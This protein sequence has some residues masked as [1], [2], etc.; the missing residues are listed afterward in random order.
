[1][2][3]VVRKI[4]IQGTAN[5]RRFLLC[6]LLVL[7]PLL[8][9]LFVRWLLDLHPFEIA[10]P[11]WVRVGGL[12]V[13]GLLWWW[14]LPAIRPFRPSTPQ[15]YSERL[16]TWAQ[17]GAMVLLGLLGYGIWVNYWPGS[18]LHA[19]PI[20]GEWT[21]AAFVA[22]GLAMIPTANPQRLPAIMVTV[23]VLAPPAYVLLRLVPWQVDVPQ[24]PLLP[25]TVGSWGLAWVIYEIYMVD[26]QRKNSGP[27]RPYGSSDAGYPLKGGRVIGIFA[28][29]L[30]LAG[31]IYVWYI[32]LHFFLVEETEFEVPLLVLILTATSTLLYLPLLPYRMFL[33]YGALEETSNLGDVKH[34]RRARDRWLFEEFKRFPIVPS[35][36]FE[37]SREIGWDKGQGDDGS[38]W[39]HYLVMIALYN[40]AAVA[41][42]LVRNLARLSYPDDRIHILLLTEKKER[43]EVDG[44]GT[45]ARSAPGASAPLTYRAARFFGKIRKDLLKYARDLVAGLLGIIVYP[46]IPR[47]FARWQSRLAREYT[48]GDPFRRNNNPSGPDQFTGDALVHGIGMLPEN[49]RQRF[50]V[51]VVPVAEGTEPQTKPRAL[52]Y[53]LYGHRDL[54]YLTDSEAFKDL[55]FEYV[56]IYDAE[57]RPEEDQLLWTIYEFEKSTR[58]ENEVEIDCLQARLMYENLNESWIISHLKAEYSSWYNFV[59]AGLSYYDL[60]IPL[61]G[62]SNHFR[63]DKL[64]ELGGWDSYNV[65]EDCDLG[66]WLAR[67]GHRVKV[68]DSTTW[69]L[70]DG[71]LRAWVKQRSR[72]IK[73]YWQ[74]YFV[75]MRSPVRL[76]MELDQTDDAEDKVWTWRRFWRM[77]SFQIM[78]GSAPLL[79]ILNTMYWFT[80]IIYFSSL[81][82]LLTTEINWF[83]RPI[84]IIYQLNAYY[85]LPWGTASFFIG[86]I[87]YFLI[88]VLGHWRHPKPGNY[89]FV[90]LWWVWYWWFMNWAAWRAML[91]FIFVPFHWEKSDHSYIS[92]N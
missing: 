9:L 21:I 23:L 46:L 60:V 53:G 36:E 77:L 12:I 29:M 89:K 25:A 38:D 17:T 61:G 90:I 65:A 5:M 52:N 32:G 24:I 78:I 19:F 58:N 63:Y 66:I 70:I 72:W 74:T 6:F 13:Y 86:N 7:M 76:W 40:E 49:K 55:S 51:A 10:S 69:E 43:D 37:L 50:H 91:E 83:T 57:D 18:G 84:F 4:R 41:E 15:S 82:S 79:P 71:E 85:V 14:L 45:A 64:R 1:M 28:S 34:R 88:V 27:R 42:R 44:S 8:F 67:K 92:A 39:P 20:S 2:L 31:I 26:G 56:T 48:F 35:E 80:T 68:I 11:D 81:I 75:H 59:L 33:L 22:V 54:E 30:L 3:L 16:A 87:I 62:T 47:H 73:G